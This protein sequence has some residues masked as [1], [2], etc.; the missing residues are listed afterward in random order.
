MNA[1]APSKAPMAKEDV[2]GVAEVNAA[3]APNISGAPLPNAT[4]VIPAI[5]SL[6][7]V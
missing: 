5:F 7:S 4:N 3:M 2:S 6:L 1:P